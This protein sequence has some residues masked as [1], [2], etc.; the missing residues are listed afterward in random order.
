MLDLV[1]QNLEICSQK[2][3]Q[4]GQCQG[5]IARWRSL[6]EWTKLAVAVGDVGQAPKVEDLARSEGASHDGELTGAL[7]MITRKS[8][9]LYSKGLIAT[10]E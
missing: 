6:M 9:G 3:R 2:F 1:S 5:L 4:R 7:V 10:G 8:S